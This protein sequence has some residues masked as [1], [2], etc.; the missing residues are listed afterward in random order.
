MGTKRGSTRANSTQATPTP[1]AG[2]RQRRVRRSRPSVRDSVAAPF[3]GQSAT[4][5]SMRAGG[6]GP[7]LRSLS[8]FGQG[9]LCPICGCSSP[10]FSPLGDPLRDDAQCLHCGSL[11][12]DRLAWLF[13]RTRTDLF[14]PAPHKLLHV[15]P[16][17]VL[18][19]RFRAHLGDGYL[20]AD[21][22]E[23][24]AMVRMDVT[25]IGSPD[26]SFDALYCSHV[27]EHVDDDRRAM[28]E[29]HRVLRP[30][31][32]A[33]VLVPVTDEETFED[34]G[35]TDPRERKKA[36]GQQDHVR[37]YGPDVVDRLCE[38][39]FTVEVIR[40]ADLVSADTAVTLGLTPASGRI[41]HCTR[42]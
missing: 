33:I 7:T 36:F 12:R 2:N 11:E 34:P 19:D 22:C 39:G 25:D 38:A 32:W 26:G 42:Q 30:G 8:Y 24:R 15:A 21:L 4:V 13:I 3:H 6:F 35:I 29:L 27:L 37:R 5:G 18:A 16:E 28:R 41:F 17:R 31:G 10:R 1:T 20:S 40:A 23:G 9:R 14:G